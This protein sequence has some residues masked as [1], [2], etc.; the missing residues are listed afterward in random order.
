MCVLFHYRS[1]WYWEDDEDTTT[2]AHM[3]TLVDKYECS[4]PLSLWI[5]QLQ[6]KI[7]QQ[8]L[9]LGYPATESNV[10]WT[11]ISLRF[12]FSDIFCDATKFVIIGA[13]EQEIEQP[14]AFEF[15]DML[16]ADLQ[17]K[18]NNDGEEEIV[19]DSTR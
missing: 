17:C 16:P 5:Q 2:L 14:G 18:S 11:H 10:R 13:W 3:A 6:R 15:F 19:V 7:E 8:G 4:K 12:G 9:E 1:E